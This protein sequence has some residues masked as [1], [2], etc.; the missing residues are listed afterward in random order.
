MKRLLIPPVF[1]FISVFFIIFFYFI[2]PAYNIVPFPYNLVGI[3]VAFF[4][5][6]ISGKSRDLFQKH[7]TT[8]DITTSSYLIT[9]GIFAKTRNPMYV[10]MILLLAGLSICFRNMFS[11]LCPAT[12]FILMHILFIPKEERLLEEEFGQE[13]NEYKRKVRKW[14]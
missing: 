2:F 6:Y 8:L 12:F 4:G 13:F 10:G 11:L 5:F 9:E 14:I 3:G 1:F 7:Q